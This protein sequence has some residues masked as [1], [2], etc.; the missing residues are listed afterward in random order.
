MTEGKTDRDRESLFQMVYGMLILS[1]VGQVAITVFNIWT[2]N[3]HWSASRIAHIV[4]L[5]FSILYLPAPWIVMRLE[6]KDLSRK[7][8][9]CQ[10]IAAN[11]KLLVSIRRSFFSVMLLSTMGTALLVG[12]LATLNW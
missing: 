8:P 6:L 9:S 11:S 7:F 12:Q 4:L 5:I 3:T 10:L 2:S 1:I